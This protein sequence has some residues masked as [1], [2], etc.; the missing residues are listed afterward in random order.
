MRLTVSIT[1]ADAADLLI[2]TLEIP[3]AAADESAS[4][5]RNRAAYPA[6]SAGSGRTS[7]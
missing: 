4:G 6:C 1:S 7:A 2:G 3:A 5:R